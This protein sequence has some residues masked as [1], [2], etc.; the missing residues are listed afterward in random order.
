M[1]RA[2][3]L[4]CRC[5]RHPCDKRTD[6]LQEDRPGRPQRS[7]KGIEVGRRTTKSR[8]NRTGVAGSTGGPERESSL[9]CGRPQCAERSGHLVEGPGVAPWEAGLDGCPDRVLE[10]L[11]KEDRDKCQCQG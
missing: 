7:K 4:S 8:Q 6:I 2:P 3:E 11:K 5:G 1:P 9:Y 10:G